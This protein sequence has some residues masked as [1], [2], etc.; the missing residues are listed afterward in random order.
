MVSSVGFLLLTGNC[1]LYFRQGAGREAVDSLQG[2]SKRTVSGCLQP[3]TANRQLMFCSS[4]YSAGNCKLSTT[5]LMKLYFIFKKIV[6]FCLYFAWWKYRKAPAGLTV[7]TYH[8]I[9]DEPDLQDPLKVSFATFEKQILY[10]KNH[11]EIISGAQLVEMIKKNISFPPQ[12]CLVTFDDGWRD[13]YT[14]ALKILKKYKVPALIFICTDY[15]GTDKTFWYEEL[16]NTLMNIP[17]NVNINT[18]VAELDMWPVFVITKLKK[19]LKS[20]LKTRRSHINSLIEVLKQF[21]EEKIRTLNR[22]LQKLLIKTGVKE[23]S[24]PTVLTWEEVEEMSHH[25]IY[26]ASHTKSH[27]ILTLIDADMVIEE[28]RASKQ[29]IEN[30]TRSKIDLLSYPNGDYNENIMDIAKEA[31]YIAAFTTT[32]GINYPHEMGK[33]LRLKRKHIHEYSSLGLSNSYS[34]LFFEIE[35]SCMANYLKYSITDYSSK[36]N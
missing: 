35:L 1:K 32:P 8:R 2:S 18:I 29:I 33:S 24:T 21:E 20:S 17:E 7:L 13:N 11:Y 4:F 30:K 34:D 10:L 22:A 25:D 6:L 31:G 12:S 26:F 14:N 27:S 5:D 19:A 9:S 36:N 15:V 23:S 16:A 28:L 3:E